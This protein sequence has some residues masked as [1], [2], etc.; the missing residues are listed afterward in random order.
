VG[1]E[2]FLKTKAGPSSKKV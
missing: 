1:S 2:I